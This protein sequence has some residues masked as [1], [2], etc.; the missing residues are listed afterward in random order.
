MA[1]VL[2]RH[3]ADPGAQLAELAW[4]FHGLYVSIHPNGHV[5]TVA[6]STDHERVLETGRWL[7][8]NGVDRRA[9]ASDPS[10]R[11]RWPGSMAERR[12]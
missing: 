12:R 4:A 8:R 2:A 3:F 7:V 1:D 10:R 11:V 5:D 6:G 9:D